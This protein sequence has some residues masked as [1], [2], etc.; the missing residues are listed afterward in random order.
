MFNGLELGVIYNALQ[1]SARQERGI[2]KRNRKA[3]NLNI[4]AGHER[5]LANIEALIPKVEAEM[6]RLHRERMESE[7][8]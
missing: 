2:I 4:V 5:D 6:H 7:Q 8:S 1:D 3:M